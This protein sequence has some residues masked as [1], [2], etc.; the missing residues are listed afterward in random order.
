M[1]PLFAAL[2]LFAAATA[3]RAEDSKPVRVGAS[4]RVDVIAPGERVDTVIDRMR[5]ATTI[6]AP[7][8]RT[9]DRAPP[10]GPEPPRAT[11]RAV[12]DA[13]RPPAGSPAIQQQP[14]PGSP[15]H[16]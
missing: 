11:D 6:P 12:P 10:R 5:R 9:A 16:R 1:K 3:A 15:P 7:D 14:P 4:H 8:A 2:S 13:P